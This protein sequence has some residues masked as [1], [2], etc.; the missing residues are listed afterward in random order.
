MFEHIYSVT[1]LCP[2][3][4]CVCVAG[5]VQFR[6]TVEDS[7]EEQGLCDPFLS[8]PGTWTSN[9]ASDQGSFAPSINLRPELGWRTKYDVEDFT[10]FQGGTVAAAGLEAG[11]SS[12]PW[13]RGGGAASWSVPTG[14]L[15][16]GAG[17]QMTGPA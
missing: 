2:S 13:Y 3:I 10:G 1:P 5:G 6:G 17:T 11:R 7:G 16:C 15:T 8:S 14:G 12:L 9:C 4:S